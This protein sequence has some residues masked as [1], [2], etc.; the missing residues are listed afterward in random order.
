VPLSGCLVLSAGHVHVQCQR[1]RRQEGEYKQSAPAE[2]GFDHVTLHA[3]MSSST[4]TR[5]L[6]ER[7]TQISQGAE[8]ASL[9]RKIRSHAL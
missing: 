3:T 2:L 1:V 9:C 8:A 5:A 7:S 4:H 6:L